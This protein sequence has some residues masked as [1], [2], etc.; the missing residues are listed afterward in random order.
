MTYMRKSIYDLTEWAMAK[1]Q[2]IQIY[3]F[4]KIL[5]TAYKIYEYEEIHC[6]L[7]RELTDN[8]Q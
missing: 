7:K 2:S 8:Y 1:K 5:L 6:R 3:N 4:A